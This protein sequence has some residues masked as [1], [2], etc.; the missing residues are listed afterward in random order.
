MTGPDAYA[1]VCATAADGIRKS[2]AFG[3]PQE[4]R[5]E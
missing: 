1:G 4:W 5:F 2:A 3:D